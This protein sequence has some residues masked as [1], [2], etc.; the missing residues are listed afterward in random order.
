MRAKRVILRIDR[1]AFS[2]TSGFGDSKDKH[3]WL[4]RTPQERIRH[5]EILRRINYGSLATRRMKRVLEFVERNSA[6]DEIARL[7]KM[8][9]R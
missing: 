3:Y 1:K 6:G 4:S 7:N 2:A 8:E 5:M 9:T